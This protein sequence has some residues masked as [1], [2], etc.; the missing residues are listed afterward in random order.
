MSSKQLP[1]LRVGETLTSGSVV[2]ASS[3]VNPSDGTLQEL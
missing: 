1:D 3:V 2:S